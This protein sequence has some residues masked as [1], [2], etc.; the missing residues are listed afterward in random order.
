MKL[1]AI[2][3]ALISLL[4]YMPFWP[5]DLYAGDVRLGDEVAIVTPG[6]LARLCPRPGCGPGEHIARIPEETILRVE[7]I[8]D[9]KIGTFSVQWFAVTHDGNKG[10]ISIFDTNRAPR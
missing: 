1:P 7:E 2:F 8:S 9:Y 4:M 10:W 5:P 6:T 3:L